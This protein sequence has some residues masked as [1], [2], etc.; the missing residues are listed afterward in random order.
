[1]QLYVR[2]KHVGYISNMS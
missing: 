1:V 2:S